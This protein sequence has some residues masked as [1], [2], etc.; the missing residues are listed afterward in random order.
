MMIGGCGAVVL[1]AT[2]LFAQADKPKT[3]NVVGLESDADN[4]TVAAPAE[5]GA[6]P[7]VV[8]ISADALVEKAK[9]S[10]TAAVESKVNTAYVKALSVE[11]MVIPP[12]AEMVKTLEEAVR[13]ILMQAGKQIGVRGHVKY[14]QRKIQLYLGMAFPAAVCRHKAQRLAVSKE[15]SRIDTLVR[16]DQVHIA[17]IAA[18]RKTFPGRCEVLAPVIIAVM[19]RLVHK[20]TQK[21]PARCI[22]NPLGSTGVLKSCRPFCTIIDRCR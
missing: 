3:I 16:Q 21:L 2:A 19:Q 22:E 20:I 9:E 14:R 18:I 1:T 15:R 8:S 17:L 7:P 10:G 5:L 13:N 4:A 6:K 11:G 12:S